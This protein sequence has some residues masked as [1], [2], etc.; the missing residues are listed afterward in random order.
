MKI[1][2]A[3]ATYNGQ[4]FIREQLESLGA[5]KRLPDELVVSD[6]RSTD[7]TLEVV[8]EFAHTA[9]FPVRIYRS[10]R[11][12]GFSD[13]FL[14]AAKLCKGDW[15]AFCDQDDIWL[16]NKLTV[17]E[18]YTDMPHNDVVLV[19][20]NAEVVDESLA[21]SGVRYLNVRKKVICSGQRLPNLWV[22]SGFTMMFRADLLSEFP[23][24][25]RGPDPRVPT[26]RLAHDVW[27]CRIAR[28]VG[29]VV[30]LPECL[31]LYRRHGLTTTTFLSGGN[32]AVRESR[33]FVR[34]VQALS[35]GGAGNYKMHARAARYQARIFD[36]FGRDLSLGRWR[37]RFRKAAADYAGLSRWL[38]IRSQ[39]CGEARFYRRLQYLSALMLRN[40]YVRF[41]GYSMNNVRMMLRDAVFDFAVALYGPRGKGRAGD[42]AA[43]ARESENA[44]LDRLKVL[45]ERT[46]R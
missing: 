30:I 20:H 46:R 13:N 5:Q 2:V 24:E 23:C 21:R 3:M 16:P 15:I 45:R 17:C 41:N 28:I 26:S 44:G 33:K 40:G 12:L 14:R 27:I 43:G 31:A 9:P 10:E 39:L 35:T 19:A 1:S 29:D 18:Q 22:A 34:R 42:A 6:D 7:R 32:E 25:E 4:R 37:E 11:N 36:R 8:E 38:L